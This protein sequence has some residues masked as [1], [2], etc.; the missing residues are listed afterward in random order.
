MTVSML[1]Q[2][3][4]A[5]DVG[6]TAVKAALVRDDVV[7]ASAER[8]LTTTVGGPGQAEQDPEQWWSAVCELTR[9]LGG[10]LR[11]DTD[12]LALTGQMQDL[13]LLG[14]HG[15]PVR[16]ALLYS[17]MRAVAEHDALVARYGARWAEAVGGQPDA[18]NVLAK[19][20]WLR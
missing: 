8:P 16:P 20:E 15:R 7:I 14:A 6:T 19:W 3:V 13:V 17:D 4:L 9:E 10:H 18:T 12:A 1:A 11:A 2:A 5:V